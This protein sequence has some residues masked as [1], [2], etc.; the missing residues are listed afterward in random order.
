MASSGWDDI[1]AHQHSAAKHTVSAAAAPRTKVF[2]SGRLT[3]D[4]AGDWESAGS[5][6]SFLVLLS[7]G[8]WVSVT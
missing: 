6:A 8:C 5:G 3:F 1:R 2:L 7:R 4:A